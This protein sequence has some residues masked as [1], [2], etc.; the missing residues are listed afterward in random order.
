MI[1]VRNSV[2]GLNSR[3][4]TAQHKLEEMTK[5]I[6]RDK[7]MKLR[8]RVTMKMS[9]ISSIVVTEAKRQYLKR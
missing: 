8:Q 2:G 1:E 5:T 6:N 9:D 7:E 3:S 4:G